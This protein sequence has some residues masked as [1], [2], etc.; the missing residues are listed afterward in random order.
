VRGPV[1][2]GDTRHVDYREFRIDLS[3]GFRDFPA[4]HHALEVYIRDECSV[5][6]DLAL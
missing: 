3:C 5:V 1:T 2:G 6:R 4:V